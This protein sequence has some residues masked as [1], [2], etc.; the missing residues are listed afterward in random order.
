MTP[1]TYEQYHRFLLK[2]TW[3][4]LRR[5]RSAGCHSL[6]Q[7]D[8][9]QEA[10]IAW[11]IAK[12]RWNPELNVPF[13]TYLG[14]GVMQHLNRF[15]QKEID[16]RLMASF[17]LDDTEEEVSTSRHEI[18]AD[19]NARTGE[20]AA[21]HNSV[22]AFVMRRLS[23]MARKFVELLES[24]PE[25]LYDEVKAIQARAEYGRKRGLCSSAPKGVTAA[26]VMDVL[27]LPSLERGSIYRE[28]RQ[29]SLEVQQQAA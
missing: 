20:D 12:E 10:A 17:E 7:Q 5:V 11:L 1:I 8:L 16:E 15:V 14:R 6:T 24:P 19:P 21:S 18:V 29:V 22:R 26:L 13:M 4:V 2:I 9:M 3:R 25:W 23:P 27:G 28:L